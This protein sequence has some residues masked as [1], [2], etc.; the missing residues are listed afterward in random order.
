MMSK[1]IY[2]LIILYDVDLGSLEYLNLLFISYKMNKNHFHSLNVDVYLHLSSAGVGRTGTFMALDFLIKQGEREGS[3]DVI[4]CVA[5]MRH[6]RVH[7]VQTVVNFLKNIITS[8]KHREVRKF[9][10]YVYYGLL[11]I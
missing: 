9:S 5:R 10:I 2:W 7:V 4:N 1:T 11:F 3:V 6:Q 8:T